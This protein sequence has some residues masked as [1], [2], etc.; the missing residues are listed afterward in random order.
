MEKTL[1]LTTGLYDSNVGVLADNENLCIKI[2]G[3]VYDNVTYYLKA[4]NG[5]KLH[6]LKFVDR[7]IEI[8]R[9]NLAYGLFKA[10]V[11]AFVENRKVKEFGVEDLILEEVGGEIKVLP[12][13]EQL[14][15]EFNEL[16]QEMV[17]L[18]QECDNTKEL[19]VKFNGLTQKV[20][21]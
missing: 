9:K 17:L 3:R 6:E 21:V 12:E 15:S 20:G 1:N 11:V 14:K 4:K 2:V 16:L 5:A 10:K 8:P 19:V 13:I 7:F 18:K